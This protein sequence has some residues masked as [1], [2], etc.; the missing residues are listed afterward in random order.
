VGP[1]RGRPVPTT[2]DDELDRR[3]AELLELTGAHQD[4]DLL[5]EILTTATELARD[6]ADRADLKIASASLAEMR[7]AFRVFAPYRDAPKAT[8]FGSART[9]VDDPLYDQARAMAQALAAEGWMVVTGAGPGIMEAGMAGAGRERSFG[10]NIQLPFETGANEVIAGDEKLVDMKYFFTRKLMLV[11]ESR[12][13]VALPGGFGTLDEVFELL[14]LMQTGKAVPAPVVLLDVPGGTYW[15]EFERFVDGELLARGLVSPEDRRLYLVTDDVDAACR[16]IMHFW[17]TFDSL[18]YVGGR[19]VVRL[20]RELT[21]AQI[22]ELN[23]RFPELPRRGRIER[24]DPLPAEVADDD[25]LDRP[26]LVLR[27]D[28]RRVGELR[29]FVDALNELGAG[30]A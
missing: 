27:I 30:A 5:T 22:D 25:R 4:R 10:V 28:L 20:R 23:A 1:R 9:R 21:D 3:I 8:M 18:R 19:L 26:R 12:A 6:A 13:F 7:R 17:S 16:E 14:T 11:K 29:T 2:G 24:T 15:R